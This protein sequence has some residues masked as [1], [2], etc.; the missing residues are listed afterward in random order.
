MFNN[1][2]QKIQSFA[3]FVFIFGTTLSVLCAL[4]SIFGI[5]NS[6]QDVVVAMNLLY[7]IIILV[8]GP[9]VSWLNGLF[10]YGFGQ[11][12]VNTDKIND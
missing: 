4:L 9:I 3:K 6:T 1:P 12:I 5:L 7:T 11:L 10:I 8:V 2:G